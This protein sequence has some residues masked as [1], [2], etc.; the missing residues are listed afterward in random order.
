MTGGKLERPWRG[1][2]RL[3]AFSAPAFFAPTFSAGC[4]SAVER[5]LFH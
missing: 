4:A 5:V 2:N 1:Y 3:P